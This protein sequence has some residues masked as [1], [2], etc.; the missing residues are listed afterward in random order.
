MTEIGHVFSWMMF[1]TQRLG[2][3]MA[4]LAGD[5]LRLDRPSRNALA[6]TFFPWATPIP[7][8]ARKSPQGHPP[9]R[10]GPPAGA[11]SIVPNPSIAIEAAVVAG[12]NSKEK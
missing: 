11:S 5:R 8:E 7:R 12:S 9:L 4:N 10:S 6:S 3:V 1:S 2:L